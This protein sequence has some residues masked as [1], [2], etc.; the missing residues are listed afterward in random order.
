MG[1]GGVPD[2]V[3]ALQFGKDWPHDQLWDGLWLVQVSEGSPSCLPRLKP[4]WLCG[5]P[6]TPVERSEATCND[7]W[8]ALLSLGSVWPPLLLVAHVQTWGK[9]TCSR[10]QHQEADGT[11]RAA[12]GQWPQPL[13]TKRTSKAGSW[14]EIS[15]FLSSF[16][17]S[18]TY[19][20][21]D[22]W[23]REMSEIAFHWQ[24]ILEIERNVGKGEGMCLTLLLRKKEPE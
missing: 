18:V 14:F 21:K 22:S 13:S 3:S 11:S 12:E 8:G 1:G 7:M 16:F 23:Y 20:C 19:N 10:N 5:Y 4:R 9:P 6:G 17:N 24:I 15:G 2:A